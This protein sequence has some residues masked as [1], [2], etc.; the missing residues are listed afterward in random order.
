MTAASI[1]IVS[2]DRAKNVKMRFRKGEGETIAFHFMIDDATYNTSGFTFLFQVFE[3]DGVAPLFELSEGSGIVNVGGTGTVG[4]TLSDENVNLDPKSY[5]WKLKIIA[6]YTKT[7]F[8]ALFTI[9][10]GPITDDEDS[11]EITVPFSLEATPIYVNLTL[12]SS[13]D[14]TNMTYDQ[15]I[16][17]Y[18]TMIPFIGVST[19]YTS[20]LPLF[21]GEESSDEIITELYETMLPFIQGSPGDDSN[22][23]YIYTQLLPLING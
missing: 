19:L 12:S 8:N 17:F 9:N 5:R 10:D 18:V 20:L 4:V 1:P 13:A 3:I 16:A 22:E 6:P 2:S 7:I 21:N 23:Y 14:F 15:A 11:I